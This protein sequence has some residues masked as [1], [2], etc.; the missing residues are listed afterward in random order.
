M[1]FSC[2]AVAI[3]IIYGLMLLWAYRIGLKDGLG[4][5]E[6]GE[7]VS[8]EP[9]QIA[10]KPPDARLDKILDNIDSYNGTPAGQKEV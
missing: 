4:V 1:L 6:T 8:M 10:G 3:G 5:K 2:I 7:V 9:R